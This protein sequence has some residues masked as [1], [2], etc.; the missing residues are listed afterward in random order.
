MKNFVRDFSFFQSL[1]FNK[2][3]MVKQDSPC[4]GATD[5]DKGCMVENLIF[6][7]K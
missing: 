6:N 2:K 4:K 7:P 5:K 3:Y 1:I